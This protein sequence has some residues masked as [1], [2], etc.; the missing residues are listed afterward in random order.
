VPLQFPFGPN[1]IR[2]PADNGIILTF[3]R[4]NLSIPD[5][6]RC[7]DRWNRSV[8]DGWLGIFQIVTIVHQFTYGGIRNGHLSI[9]HAFY[10]ILAAGLFQF[11]RGDSVLRRSFQ[12]AHRQPSRFRI[13]VGVGNGMDI[14]VN[15]LVEKGAGSF[16]AHF[17]SSLSLSGIAKSSTGWRWQSMTTDVS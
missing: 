11:R 12:A 6:H 15:P 5:A 7:K 17:A 8:C 4:F 10:Q 1:F 2:A 3:A 16:K 14:V 9:T 13:V